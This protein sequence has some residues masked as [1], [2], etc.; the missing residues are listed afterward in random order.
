MKILFVSAAN[1][2]HTV[3]WVNAFA[4]RGHEVYLVSN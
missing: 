1:S 3:R 4:E 2:T